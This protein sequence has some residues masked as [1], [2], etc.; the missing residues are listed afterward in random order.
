MFVVMQEK[1]YNYC[2][3][4]VCKAPN[5]FRM[6]SH[7]FHSVNSSRESGEGGGVGRLSLFSGPGSIGMLKLGSRFLL[8][9]TAVIVSGLLD[10]HSFTSNW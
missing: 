1:L 6:H 2:A 10:Q 3:V 4:D 7:A 8:I 9:L 5:V